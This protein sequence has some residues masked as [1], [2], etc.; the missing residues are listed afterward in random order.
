MAVMDDRDPLFIRHRRNEASSVIVAHIARAADAADEI[1]TD[2]AT[3]WTFFIGSHSYY[4]TLDHAAVAS[5][6]Y[7]GQSIPVTPLG[8]YPEFILSGAIASGDLEESENFQRKIVF[9]S[10]TYRDS[11]A[12][13][14][15]EPLSFL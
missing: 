2:S 6:M 1:A 9:P 4:L 7:G 15:F 8:R 5:P 3:P 14:W 12:E 11:G 13:I 10:A